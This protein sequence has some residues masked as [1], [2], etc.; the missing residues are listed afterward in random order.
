MSRPL[1]SALLD[2]LATIVGEGDLLLDPVS[3]A[4]AAADIFV[5]P[6]AVAA[7]AVIR[8]GSTE[9]MSHVMQ[10]LAKSDVAVV[11]RG[12]GLSYTA[13]VVPA[14]AAVVVDCLRLKQIQVF[15]QDMYAI[16]GAGTTWLELYEA[17]KPLGLRAAQISPISGSHSTIG[18][19][20]SQNL[21]GG[22]EHFIGLKVVLADG[23]VVTTGSAAKSGANAFARYAGPDLTGLFLGDCGAFGIKTD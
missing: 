23:T 16:V 21:P 9:Q 14:T 1:P 8:P 3:C 6:D 13:G 7:Q 17:L 11:P 10:A 12:A 5:W 20:A 22:L 18:G 4:A 2:E 19:A 15:A